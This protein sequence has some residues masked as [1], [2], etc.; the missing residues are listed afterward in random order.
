MQPIDFIDPHCFVG[1]TEL[2]NG[3]I[4]P[5]TEDSKHTF[6]NWRFKTEPTLNGNKI[7]WLIAD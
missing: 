4:T 5:I 6:S 7:E 3:I 2:P 1:T